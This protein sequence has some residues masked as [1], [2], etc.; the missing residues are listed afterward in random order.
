MHASHILSSGTL[1][2]QQAIMLRV[3]ADMG[4]SCLVAVDT[5]LAADDAGIAD[6]SACIQLPIWESL[7]K[8]ILVQQVMVCCQ[9]D[10][11]QTPLLQ[12]HAPQG[13]CTAT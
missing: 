13:T 12:L 6:L 7:L 1:M 8:V 4:C 11:D 10:S 2:Q 5:A 9:A 3:V